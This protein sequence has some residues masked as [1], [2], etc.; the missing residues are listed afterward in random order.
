MYKRIVLILLLF[1]ISRQVQAQYYSLGQEA[2]SIRWKQI[3]T[4]HFQ[5]IF[6]QETEESSQEIASLLEHSF[7]L[8]SETMPADV[9]RIPVILHYESVISN[10]NVI[11]AP[12]RIELFL[13]PTQHSYADVWENQLASHELRHYVQISSLNQGITKYLQY[14]FGEQA[15][16]AVLGLYIPLWFLEGDAVLTET[17]LSNSGRGRLAAFEMPLKTQILEK[18]IYSY[19]KAVFGSYKDFTPDYYCLGYHLVTTARKNYGAAF[20]QNTL[21]NVA[22][23]PYAI[24][25]FSRGI[26]K[27]SGFSK[28]A[29]YQNSMQELEKEWRKQ[30]AENEHNTIVS[31]DKDKTY[32]S[33][34]HA[35]K[36]DEQHFFA[37]KKSHRA[38][39][40][41]VIIDNHNKEKKIHY[42]G[43]YFP[44]KITVK[45]KKILWAE[46][47]YDPRWDHRSWTKI[48][49]YDM[50]KKRLHTICKK[51]K[52][53]APSFS[54][55]GKK[56]VCSEVLKTENNLVII[57]ADNG[58]RIKEVQSPENAFIQTPFFAKGDSSVFCI[59]I[60]PLGKA[61]YT[62]DLIQEKWEIIG[63]PSFREIKNPF[64]YQNSIFFTSDM[65]GVDNIYA[66]SLSN[67]S[68]YR[69]V[70][71][72]YGAD[73]ASIFKDSLVYSNYTADGFEIRSSA[74]ENLTW[75]KIEDIENQSINLWEIPLKEEKGVINFAEIGDSVYEV[76]KYSKLLHLFNIHSWAP[77]NIDYSNNRI[78]PGL[79][80][81]SQ[82]ALSTS[83]AAV[84]FDYN[85]ND[86]INTY[87]AEYTYEGLYPKFNFRAEHGKIKDYYTEGEESHAFFRKET[88]MNLGISLP[89]LFTKKHYSRNL[90]ISSNYGLKS[91]E[92]LHS[93]PSD[94]PKGKMEFGR[95]RLYFSNIRKSNSANIYPRF[96]QF[97][98][99]NSQHSFSSGEMDLGHAFS[100]AS[101]F[102]F[103]A[104]GKND[105]FYLYGAYQ[106]KEDGTTYRFN[107]L[108]SNPRGFHDIFE[109][110]IYAYKFNYA[111]ALAYPDFNIGSLIYVK[112]IRLH[113][114]FD[115]SLSEKKVY[116]STGLAMIFDS[117]LLH[118]I[119]PI[120]FGFRPN[121]LI[122]DKAFSYDV[123]FE[124]GFNQL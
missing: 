34:I 44:E 119:A 36:I 86:K 46:K 20:W 93:T 5:L 27:Q 71:A 118:F 6:P 104:F 12:R 48:M 92:H 1:L 62:Y 52:Y 79:S 29:F 109:K 114:F 59:L 83:T 49:L 117:H 18:G 58:E 56:I 7:N 45:N 10:G 69:V 25:P 17:L 64:Y 54:S 67:D 99:I 84:G 68:I 2:A 105:G 39:D 102:Y 38:I 112:R 26:K 97:V 123:L 28:K 91:I 106:W 63:E 98:D 61:F 65:H 70:S 14:F 9:K 8:V 87:F 77:L 115:Q 96:G 90:Y 55:D 88:N 66:Y 116:R 113:C 73:Y 94:Y 51:S 85:Y 4:A 11:W 15:L 95:H 121:Y 103:P 40:E 72:K 108:I 21:E 50:E 111:G 81:F 37:V 74:L 22:R 16:G 78:N 101:G 19:E 76:E 33:Y 47:Q 120:S 82:N 35:Q 13:T 107:N 100:L 24:T 75:E 89:L 41:F 53:F 60:S 124:I 32:T 57:S 3:K 30:E 80:I 122:D 43:F 23:K 31:P 42:P 110:M